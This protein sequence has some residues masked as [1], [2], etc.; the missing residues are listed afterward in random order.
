MLSGDY[1]FYLRVVLRVT[2]FEGRTFTNVERGMTVFTEWPRVQVKLWQELRELV[3][4]AF[5]RNPAGMGAAHDM[6]DPVP[7]G[8]QIPCAL[9]AWCEG[10]Y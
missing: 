6:G 7:Q 9:Y 4:R 1:F 2:F 5:L 10:S 3:S 8:A